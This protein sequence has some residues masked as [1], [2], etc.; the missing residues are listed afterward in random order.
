MNEIK[1]P[2]CGATFTVDESLYA[3]IAEKVRKEVIEQEQKAKAEAL[4]EKEESLK[5]KYESELKLTKQEG[6]MTLKDELAKK[7]AEIKEYQLK[8]QGAEKD[9]K[10]SIAYALSKQETEIAKLKGELDTASKQVEIEVAKAIAE[11]QKK[12]S[13]LELEKKDLLNKLQLQEEQEKAALRMT[14][15][16]YK[17]IIQGKDE[18]IA[19]YK[20]F[21]AKLSTKAIGESLEQYC[22]NEFNKIRAYVYPYAYFDKDNIAVEGTK[23]D[24]VFRNKDENGTEYL[25]IMFEMKNEADGTATKHKNSDFFKKLDEDRKKK[26][27]EYAVLV[28]LLEADSELYN[29]G[30]VDVSY[31]FP[32]MFVIRPQFFL[33]L[34]ALL[35]KA[36]KK[37]AKTLAL[38]EEEKKQSIDV[39]NFESKLLA[40]QDAFGKNFTSAC[41]H[42][43]AAIK[44]IDDAIAKL[45]KV[46]GD[47]DTS[48]NQLRLANDKAQALTIKK[49]TKDSPGLRAKFEAIDVDSKN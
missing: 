1:C 14:E 37:N 20:D 22:L 27:C 47:L 39:E 32:N 17:I 44:E 13:S 10:D 9:K 35:D 36:S 41:A 46:R 18:E 26:G 12:S 4:K 29:T 3:E 42:Y 48:R 19:H 6:E 45:N 21:K 43:D 8:L 38:I 7:D 5:M 25:S 28:S 34:I 16:K 40:F 24:F 23:G 49:L 30:I 15:D 2:K 33:P 31:E 11:E